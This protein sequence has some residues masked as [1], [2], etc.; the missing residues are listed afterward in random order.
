MNILSCELFFFFFSQISLCFDH[1]E[2]RLKPLQLQVV[3]PDE[4]GTEQAL[5]DLA[6]EDDS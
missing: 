3:R 4:C 2:V 6:K 5:D 1:T